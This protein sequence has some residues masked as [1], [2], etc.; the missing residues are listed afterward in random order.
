[1]LE[2]LLRA[3]SSEW[4]GP[5]FAQLERLVNRWATTEVLPAEAVLDI[6]SLIAKYGRQLGDQGPAAT[7]RIARQLD[8]FGDDAVD[9]VQQLV[10]LDKLYAATGNFAGVSAA[11]LHWLLRN[12]EGGLLDTRTV[13]GLTRF[14]R[15][16]ANEDDI[17][18]FNTTLFRF[19][20]HWRRDGSEPA[21]NTV[22]KV[23]S[24]LGC[25][26]LETFLKQYGRVKGEVM[27]TDPVTGEKKF[28][29]RMLE[30]VT[31]GPPLSIYALEDG[32]IVVR[33]IQLVPGQKVAIES[34]VFKSDTWTTATRRV[35]GE[36]ALTGFGAVDPARLG[37]GHSLLAITGDVLGDP[38]DP[39]RLAAILEELN[40]I[41]GYERRAGV[42]ILPKLEPGY[43]ADAYGLIRRLDPLP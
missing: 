38:P 2:E 41:P 10:A 18:G 29:D 40:A 28:I 31:A 17:V 23:K 1:M 20:E 36:E 21:M 9:V 39:A 12:L 37:D 15:I 30:V 4:D 43:R 7:A 14:T 5:T 34:K 22:S 27:V 13:E 42:I 11:D 3:V 35:A 8:R 33:Q 24:V 16:N 32:Q 26:D 25:M 19:M 6:V